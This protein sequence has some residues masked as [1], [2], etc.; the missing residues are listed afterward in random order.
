M[1]WI[2]LCL[3]VVQWT[4]SLQGV[5]DSLGISR[6]FALILERLTIGLFE[7][8]KKK[9]KVRRDAGER[10]PSWMTA[11]ASVGCHAAGKSAA[12][13]LGTHCPRALTQ[14]WYCC[15]CCPCVGW[16]QFDAICLAFSWGCH[17]GARRL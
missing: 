12:V 17:F 16:A 6:P 15:A 9:E 7:E 14:C 5:W 13:S 3:G 10:I 1:G 4:P 2:F 8:K 11:H